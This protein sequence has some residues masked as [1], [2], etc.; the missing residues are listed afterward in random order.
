MAEQLGRILDL[1]ERPVE[2]RIEEVIKV[3]QTNEDDVF[4]ELTE[5]TSSNRLDPKELR[6]HSH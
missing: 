5:R 3:D 6:S 2:R 4:L 1:F